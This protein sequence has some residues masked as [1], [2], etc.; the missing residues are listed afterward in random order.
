M[1]HN[2]NY[3]FNSIIHKFVLTTIFIF[4]FDMITI[5]FSY[6]TYIEHSNNLIICLI[7]FLS[8]VLSLS[9]FFYLVC[10]VSFT[11]VHIIN[12]IT[13]CMWIIAFTYFNIIGIYNKYMIV[14]AFVG[15]IQSALT[16]AAF[17]YFTTKFDIHINNFKI[18]KYR[19]KIHHDCVSNDCKSCPCSICLDKNKKS[20]LL[21]CN[22]MFHIACWYKHEFFNKN[23]LRCPNCRSA[24]K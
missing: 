7:L 8:C 4:I 11:T 14:F 24:L 9:K 6:I 1:Y 20:F 12:L 3:I 13:L 22:H 23:N 15:L 21:S 19:T 10:G 16:I 5:I 17:D 18:K 2:L